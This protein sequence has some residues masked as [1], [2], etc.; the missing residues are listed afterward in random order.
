MHLITCLDAKLIKVPF[1]IIVFMTLDISNPYL[2]QENNEMKLICI[3]NSQMEHYMR[4]YIVILSYSSVL[5]SIFLFL[6]AELQLQVLLYVWF[7]HIQKTH[8]CLDEKM[9]FIY[10]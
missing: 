7:Q 5:Y 9:F 4:H 6:V 8:L 2:A 10:L 1:I 3:R